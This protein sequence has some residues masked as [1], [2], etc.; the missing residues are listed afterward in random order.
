MQ[1]DPHVSVLIAAA[2]NSLDSYFI[3]F[4]SLYTHI[5]SSTSKAIGANKKVGE[6]KKEGFWFAV[7][8]RH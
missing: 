2:L 6:D 4:P 1:R 5:G 7:V 3:I 8:E